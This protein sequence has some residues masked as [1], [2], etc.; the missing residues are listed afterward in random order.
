MIKVEN[1]FKKY[2]NNDFYSSNGVSFNV[3]E[4]TI[5][6]LLGNNGAGK[7]TIMK[8]LSTVYKPD[9]GRVLINDLD[10]MDKEIEIKKILGIVFETPRLF[11]DLTGREN[12]EYIGELFGINKE[13]I[14]ER[15]KSMYEELEVD[16][17]D[18]FVNTYSKGMKQ[19]IAIIR[20]LITNP[21][22]VL[23]DEPTSGLDIVSRN[24]IRKYISGLKDKT[25]VITSHVAED[26]E[27]LCDKVVILKKG[28]VCEDTDIE[29]LKIKYKANSFEEAYVNIQKIKEG[30]AYV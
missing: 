3:E 9:K 7:S 21:K 5:C 30:K 1:V 16:F 12:I 13:T 29:K 20:A 26:I 23:M 24:L 22:I 27:A 10:T 8:M 18:K 28:N 11:E 6:G 25:I 2:L 14:R 19:K 15:C 4:N 17:E